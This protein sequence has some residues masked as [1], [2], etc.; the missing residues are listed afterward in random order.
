[1][2]ARSR[3]INIFNMSL[4]DI[5]C[6]ALGA[7]CFMMLVLLPYYK[8][9]GKETDLHDQEVKT[10][11]LL[12]E[13]NK[14]RAQAQDS[15]I[16]QQMSQ[17]VDK[18]QDQLKQ[19]QGQLN[20]MAAENDQLKNQNESLSAKN[21]KQASQLDM[22]HP[23]LVSAASYPPQELDVYLESDGVSEKNQSNPPFDPSKAHQPTFFTGD[24]AGWWASSGV[25][26]WM[27]RDAPT[28]SRYKLYVKTAPTADPSGSP[29]TTTVKGLAFSDAWSL[30]LPDVTLTPAR[31]WT[32]VGTLSLPKEGKPTFHEAT[33]T[34]RDAEWSKLAKS[35]P[36]QQTRPSATTA[37]AM[38]FPV[39][40]AQPSTAPLSPEQRRALL[41]KL[42]KERRER[43]NERPPAAGTS[44]SQSP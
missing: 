20:Q 29:A 4:L 13:L 30:T 31:F 41:E 37:P 15:A 25:T 8:P 6:G 42:E 21:A 14:L 38:P 32:L 44:P 17:L 26:T 22:R 16:A 9:P 43:Q 36:P 5:L 33:Q 1:M 12:D 18:L 11:D 10:Q 2:R 40:T 23:F 34:E 27:T 19:M 24:V 28:P 7:F 39:Q 35:S 3:E